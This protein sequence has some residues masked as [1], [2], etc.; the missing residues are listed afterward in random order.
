VPP[1][2]PAELGRQQVV[3]RACA[4]GRRRDQLAVEPPPEDDELDE[5]DE[6]L[7]EDDELEEESEPPFADLLVDEPLLDEVSA[8][9]A[10]LRLSVR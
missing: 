8:A 4:C 10:D 3:D 9:D 6:V 2:A 7:D 5:D 1:S